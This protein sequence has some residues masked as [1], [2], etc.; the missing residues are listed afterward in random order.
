MASVRDVQQRNWMAES[1][2]DSRAWPSNFH[3]SAR[4]LPI[5]FFRE[6]DG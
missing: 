4:M 3:A 6:I 2:S 1:C 5:N